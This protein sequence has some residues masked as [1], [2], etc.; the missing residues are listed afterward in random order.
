MK[1]SQ[2]KSVRQH[3]GK[4]N[5]RGIINY[6]YQLSRIYLYIWYMTYENVCKVNSVTGINMTAI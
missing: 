6:Y 1:D 4:I 3:T 2:F 5:T